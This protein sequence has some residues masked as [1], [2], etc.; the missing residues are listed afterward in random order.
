M[1]KVGL[2]TASSTPN[3]LQIWLIKVVLPAPMGAKNAQMVLSP[4]S[5]NKVDAMV[6]IRS[7]W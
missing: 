3:C 4:Y 6:S 7:K 5:F 2:E 1:A